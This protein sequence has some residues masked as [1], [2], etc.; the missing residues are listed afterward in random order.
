MA[1]AGADRVLAMSASW[2]RE[3][4]DRL[5]V[6][7]MQ[8]VPHGFDLG[9]LAPLASR[10]RD[11]RPRAVSIGPITDRMA[12]DLLLRAMA[13]VWETAP[14]TE[15]HFIG[16]GDARA[17]TE[18]L[19]RELEPSGQRITFHGWIDPVHPRL[20]DFDVFVSASRSEDQTL[21]IIEA[22]LA[23]LPIVATELDGVADLVERS[24]AGI[25]VPKDAPR[26]LAAALMVTLTTGA[27]ARQ[28][29][30][31]DGERFARAEFGIEAHVDRLHEVYGWRKPAT[32][33]APASVAAAAGQP[34]LRLHLG[35]GPDRRHGWIN[36]DARVEV[37][38]DVVA[39][40]DALPMFADAS[41]DE[42]EACH[43]FEHLT[44]HEAER[45]LVEWRRV[46]KPGGTLMLE[47]PNLDDCVRLLAADP[48]SEDHAL[49]MIGI[50]GWPEGVESDG[51]AQ[52]HKWGWTPRS[53]GAALS[54]AGFDEIV[55]EPVTQSWRAATRV[56]RDFRLRARRPAAV[57]TT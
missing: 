51:V 46:L 5:G 26:K 41:V 49:G 9:R 25:T 4:R 30:A 3:L 55:P 17:K 33:T 7:S 39:R 34:P 50:F 20:Q 22:M 56:G 8:V 10:A 42:I 24:R 16:D 40:A 45:A 14:E 2:A 21:V 37:E 35:C 36:V 32:S 29:L 38:P 11:R 43:L 15:L 18:A 12:P 27:E 44:P 57:M 28:E 23:G 48:E 47:L 1:L 31:A 54:R 19:A 13:R 6:T 52:V 53:L